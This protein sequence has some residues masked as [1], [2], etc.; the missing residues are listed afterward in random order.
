MREECLY[1]EGIGDEVVFRIPSL[2]VD[3]RVLTG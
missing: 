2:A 3:V 1:S